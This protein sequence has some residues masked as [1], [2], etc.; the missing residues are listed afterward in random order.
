MAI[1]RIIEY[2]ADLNNRDTKLDNKFL[3]YDNIDKVSIDISQIDA[4][5]T[6]ASAK[7]FFVCYTYSDKKKYTEIKCTIDVENKKKYH[8]KYLRILEVM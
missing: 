5:F 6:S 8:L 3:S 7:S 4:D 1:E 2:Q